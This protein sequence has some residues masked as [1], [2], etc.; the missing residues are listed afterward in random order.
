MGSTSM[1]RV[2]SIIKMIF[3]ESSWP[4]FILLRSL[5]AKIIYTTIFYFVATITKLFSGRWDL[6]NYAIS[7]LSFIRL[8]ETAEDFETIHEM[9]DTIYSV[10]PVYDLAQEPVSRQEH[11]K[12]YIYKLRSAAIYGDSN[13]IAKGK[14][15]IY[16]IQNFK[17]NKN[18]I[19]RDINMPYYSGR[20]ALIRQ[21]PTFEV[22]PEGIKINGKYS[23]NYYHYLFEQISKL[24]YVNTSSI[25]KDVPLLVDGSICTV[26]QYQELLK[27][28]LNGRRVKYLKKNKKYCINKLYIIPSGSHIASNYV[29]D[30]RMSFTDNS[31][32]YLPLRYIVD[33]VPKTCQQSKIFPE[34]IYISRR[35]ASGRRSFN[36]EEVFKTLESLNYQRVNVDDYSIS[37]QAYLF[38]NAKYIVGGSG[39]AFSNLIYCN[40]GCKVICLT[41]YQYDI[42]LFSTLA[43]YSGAELIYLASN[44]TSMVSRIHDSFSV[45]IKRLT[46]LLKG[47]HKQ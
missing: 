6:F 11:C 7:E 26:P 2:K 9:A 47:L 23:W 13:I 21:I 14:K 27:Y 32:S 17:A 15:V 36:E 4:Y 25:P 18:I 8:N 5:K 33:K 3:P 22:V 39:A 42:S 35:N 38:N 1:S 41:N 40:K 31:F 12:L 30:S 43:Q 10:K 45:D 19:I 37:E 28:V 20:K 34:R 24:Y 29:D 44:K 16:E 46:L